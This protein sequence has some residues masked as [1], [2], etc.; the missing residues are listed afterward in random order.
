MRFHELYE[1]APPGRKAKRFIK[2]AAPSF[3]ERYGD[4]WKTVLYAKAWKMFGESVEEPEDGSSLLRKLLNAAT[5]HGAEFP[6]DSYGSSVTPHQ[7]R[8]EVKGAAAI[9]FFQSPRASRMADDAG[10]SLTTFEPKNRSSGLHDDGKPRIVT[11][12]QVRLEN[13]NGAPFGSFNYPVPTEL[14][15]VTRREN[16]ESILRNGLEPKTSSRPNLHRYRNRIFL[17]TSKAGAEK[18]LENFI[19]VD[20]D[21]DYVILKID[22]TAVTPIFIDQEFKRFGAWTPTPIPPSAISMSQSLSEGVEMVS[23]PGGLDTKVLINPTQEMVKN[24]ALGVMRRRGGPIRMRGICLDRKTLYLWD[25]WDAIHQDIVEALA[26]DSQYHSMSQFEVDGALIEP[27]KL[28]D[29]DIW[30]NRYMEDVEDGCR[31]AIRY[32]NS[33]AES[34]GDDIRY[35]RFF[36]KN[37]RIIYAPRGCDH[38]HAGL[39]QARRIRS[40]G[41]GC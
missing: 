6:R 31:E 11:S 34:A 36:W 33:L 18:T 21:H 8:T 39:D 37:G 27:T 28:G 40:L 29:Y 7:I 35:D 24:F 41:N 17:A 12:M 14:Y 9:A 32:K 5:Q 26:L 23:V 3:K 1:K 19:R 25:S 16:V 30:D 4:A 13:E 20:G 2:K 10:W 38:G 15:H 22:P